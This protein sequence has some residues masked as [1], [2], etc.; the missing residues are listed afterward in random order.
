MLQEVE[1]IPEH[2]FH[3]GTFNLMIEVLRIYLRILILDLWHTDI[4]N[5][6]WNA[7]FQETWNL[8]TEYKVPYV[9]LPL[10]LSIPGLIQIIQNSH[11][12]IT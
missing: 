3:N 12:S 11:L 4:L 7:G 8:D 9:I 2:Q 6:H 5:F 10:V 1:V